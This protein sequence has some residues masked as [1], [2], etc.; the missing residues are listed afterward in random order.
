ML[1]NSSQ[2]HLSN[3]QGVGTVWAIHVSFVYT[4][5]LSK[6]SYSHTGLILLIA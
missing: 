4:G 5:L 2:F 1:I 6:Q 3:W